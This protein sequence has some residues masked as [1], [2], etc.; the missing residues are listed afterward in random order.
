VLVYIAVSISKFHHPPLFLGLLLLTIFP[1]SWLFLL[2]MFS[3]FDSVLYI[4]SFT[5]LNAVFCCF[6]S[7][8]D[9]FYSSRQLTLFVD[10]FDPFR[11][12][13]MLC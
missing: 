12:V 6:P 5:S 7:N 2:H 4:V 11:L 1:P 13:L 3:D 9:R 10:H 8:T